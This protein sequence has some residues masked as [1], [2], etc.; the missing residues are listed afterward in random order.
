MSKTLSSEAVIAGL[1]L[2]IKELSQRISEMASSS[3]YPR[4]GK[5]LKEIETTA[6]AATRELA[7]LISAKRLQQA[8]DSQELN[9]AVAETAKGFPQKFKNYGKRVVRVRMSGGTEFELFA[10]YHARACYEKN[11]KGG[12]F[13]LDSDEHI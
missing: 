6:Q 4:N 12:F 8:L 11:H 7:D 1:D 13:W 10:S 2:R 9:E 3:G 5:E